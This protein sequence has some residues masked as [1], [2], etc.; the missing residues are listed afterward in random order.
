MFLLP[1]AASEA[2][3]SSYYLNYIVHGNLGCAYWL[4][5]ELTNPRPRGRGDDASLD[6]QSDDE[7]DVISESQLPPPPVLLS[8]SDRA[9]ELYEKA[10]ASYV[11]A[12][13]EDTRRNVL[14]E[15]GGPRVRLG[16]RPIALAIDAETLEMRRYVQRGVERERDAILRRMGLL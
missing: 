16:W 15:A 6:V 3:H 4:Q 11:K 5:A 13:D 10:R 9:T 8:A 7:E 2:R 14:V 12:F 1:H